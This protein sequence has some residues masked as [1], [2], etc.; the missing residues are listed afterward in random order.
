MERE[1][2]LAMFDRILAPGGRI[3]V[4][5]SRAAGAE[6]NPWRSAYDALLR[7]VGEAGVVGHRQVYQHWFDGSRFTKIGGIKVSCRHNVSP[8][9]LVERAL[10]R[11]TTSPAV[12]GT[13]TEAF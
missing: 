6:V 10:T 9:A 1:A 13:K 4:C 11:S 3:V 8:A 2:T 12:L 5:G 7:S